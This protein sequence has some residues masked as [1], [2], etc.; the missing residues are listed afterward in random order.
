MF[1]ESPVVNWERP[2]RTAARTKVLGPKEVFQPPMERVLPLP[3]PASRPNILQDIHTI[4]LRVS[5]ASLISEKALYPA[6]KDSRW[7]FHRV[8]NTYQ[9][10]NIE[11]GKLK[12]FHIN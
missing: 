4:E 9:S 6:D 2:P 11:K 1:V 10:I 8:V 12:C 5:L 3:K 7:G